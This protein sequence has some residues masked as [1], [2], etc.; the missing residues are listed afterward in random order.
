[1]TKA[2]FRTG[3]FAASLSNATSALLTPLI[4]CLGLLQVRR[5]LF[6]AFGC[7]KSL[8]AT[9]FLLKGGLFREGFL[10]VFIT[11]L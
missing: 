8:L 10:T 4:S 3:S 6:L 11:H 2:S 5:V 7:R 9:G 1:M